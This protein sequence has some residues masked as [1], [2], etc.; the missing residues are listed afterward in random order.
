M[1]LSY[2]SRLLLIR[3]SVSETYRSLAQRLAPFS[4][5]STPISVQAI[6]QHSWL[7]TATLRGNVMSI[8]TIT[9][10]LVA[11]A[12]ALSVSIASAASFPIEPPIAAAIPWSSQRALSLALEPPAFQTTL[13]GLPNV[14]QLYY[15]TT[16]YTFAG[17][18][19]PMRVLVRLQVFSR[20]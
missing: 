18:I 1:R 12:L 19:C 7:D 11:A 17:P 5:R 8:R 4:D 16:C 9:P 20:D 14:V 6:D 13:P 15:A 3:T 10:L 2:P